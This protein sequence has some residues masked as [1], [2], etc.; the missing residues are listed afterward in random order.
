MRGVKRTERLQEEHRG[1]TS[2][3]HQESPSHLEDE[4]RRKSSWSFWR[5]TRVSFYAKFKPRIT[6]YNT[7]EQTAVQT[8]QH[9]QSGSSVSVKPAASRPTSKL[10]SNRKWCKSRCCDDHWVVCWYSLIDWWRCSEL[11]GWLTQ[12]DIKAVLFYGLYHSGGRPMCVSPTD[13]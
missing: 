9:C 11:I 3:L 1:N 2:L 6:G 10:S 8:L 7:H 12:T 13:R 5:K 4:K